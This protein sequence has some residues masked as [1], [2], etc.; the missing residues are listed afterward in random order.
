A[1]ANASFNVVATGCEGFTYQW[2]KN[3][4]PLPGQ[5]N[6]ILTLSNVV[7]TNAG[8]YSVLVSAPCRTVINSA[9]LTVNT[10][11]Q[12]VTP[13]TNLIGVIGSNVTLSVAATGTTLSYAWYHGGVLLGTGSS[14]SRNNLSQNDAGTY[15][16]VV[17]SASCGGP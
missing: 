3:G 6:T 2:R 15:C 9:T 17:T 16:V 8:V 7:A 12:I 13:P 14:L 4:V 11:A 10:P 5:T 1:G